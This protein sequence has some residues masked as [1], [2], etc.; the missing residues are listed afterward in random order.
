MKIDKTK[1]KRIQVAVIGK[2]RV[3]T[4]I[5]HALEARGKRFKLFAHLAARA[6]TRALTK[7]L[8]E[9]GGPDVM[10]LATRD[11]SISPASRRIVP[12]CGKNLRIV[13]HCAGSIA[14]AAIIARGSIAKATFHP[15]QTFP[16]PDADLLRGINITISTPHASAATTLRALAEELGAEQTLM[17]RPEDLPLYHAAAVY[18]A[19]FLTLLVTVVEQIAKAVRIEEKQM[20]SALRPIMTQALENALEHNSRDV[21]TG[22]L[23]RGYDRSITAHRKA[24][25]KFPPIVEKI[26]TDFVE[27]AKEYKL[28]GGAK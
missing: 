3:G 11:L 12:F 14:P 6:S 9:K 18:G 24:L 23:A 16:K 8:R 15:L 1:K 10:I 13:A 7:A 27:L 25:W 20:K 19:N 26:Y 4:S 2:G 5:A 17:I 28:Y 21:L 22:P